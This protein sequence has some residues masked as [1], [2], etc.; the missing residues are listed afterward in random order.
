MR[1]SLQEMK[2]LGFRVFLLVLITNED[3]FVREAQAL[4]MFGKGYTYGPCLTASCAPWC[5]RTAWADLWLCD[6]VL[7]LQIC[8]ARYAKGWLRR[9]HSISYCAS[10]PR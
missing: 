9:V 6:T 2:D 7:S 3:E 8:H 4:D 1:Q 5:D 10:A